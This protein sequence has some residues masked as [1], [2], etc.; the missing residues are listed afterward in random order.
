MLSQKLDPGAGLKEREERGPFE[1][2]S[3][4]DL[5]LAL[6]RSK[7]GLQSDLPSDEQLYYWGR[8]AGMKPRRTCL[9]LNAF[10]M[11]EILYIRSGGISGVQVVHLIF[12]ATDFIS[13][14]MYYE[15]LGR[16]RFSNLSSIARQMGE[17]GA[18]ENDRY[19]GW[20]GFS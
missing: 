14:E 2:A 19:K 7:A 16:L 17:E 13:R 1:T 15:V 10:T 20:K 5:L 3:E 18:V 11:R 12:Y 9:S 6:Y 4:K 8:A